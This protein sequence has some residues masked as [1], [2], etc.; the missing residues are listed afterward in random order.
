LLISSIQN[1]E[2]VAY[3]T[4]FSGVSSDL[5]EEVTRFDVKPASEVPS[6]F[7]QLE[8]GIDPLA[9]ECN[10]NLVFM[11]KFEN[12]KPACVT[13]QTAQ[14][15]VERNWGW[16]ITVSYR[17]CNSEPCDATPYPERHVS[18]SIIFDFSN[19]TTAN[20]FGIKAQVIYDYD[21]Y[22]MKGSFKDFQIN[23]TS[24]KGVQFVSYEVC[25]GSSCMKDKLNILNVL[26]E[27]TQTKEPPNYNG[28][29]G[30]ITR[31]S[32]I[33]RS[34]IDWNVGDTV[35]IVVRVYSVRLTVEEGLVGYPDG[36]VTLDL[37]KSQIVSLLKS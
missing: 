27:K 32:I 14:K 18:E 9:V 37:G 25:D 12:S 36:I 29:G 35:H 23:L 28:L 10:S 1:D 6:P 22:V 31:P 11:H 7:K 4:K 26:M 19:S 2:D 34:P 3:G 24:Q 21:H 30:F 33:T 20:P 15:L 16:I 17:N 13:L 5:P 8:N